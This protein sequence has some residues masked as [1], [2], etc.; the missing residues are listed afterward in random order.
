M[1]TRDGFHPEDIYNH[2]MAAEDSEEFKNFTNYSEDY[3]IFTVFAYIH[4]GVHLTLSES[5]WPF[6]DRWDTSCRGFVLIKKEH[7]DEE[8]AVKA[9]QSLI[10]E[11]NSVLAGDVYGF[12]IEKPTDW[13]TIAEKDLEQLFF[14]K[15]YP[16]KED[17]LKKCRKE[18]IH[19]TIDS[20]WRYVGLPDES[21]C[22]EDAKHVIDGY[23]T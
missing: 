3:Y 1:V 5:N 2:I 14:E 16:S 6:S 12:I 15:S 4:S 19:E 20:C 18:V 11:Y 21:G 17:Y 7:F 22:I 10:K 13:L 8:A 9:A 23:D